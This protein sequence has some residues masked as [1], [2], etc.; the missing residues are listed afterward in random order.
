[1]LAFF[2]LEQSVLPAV[3]IVDLYGMIVFPFKGD[4]ITEESLTTFVTDFSAHKV[5]VCGLFVKFTKC[6]FMGMC[7]KPNHYP[8]TGKIVPSSI[9]PQTFLRA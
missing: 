4:A 8:M 6:K 9:S 7:R 1:V 3:R 5:K 2:G